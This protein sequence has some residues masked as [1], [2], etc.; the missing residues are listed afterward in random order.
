M[1]AEAD[2]DQTFVAG[3]MTPETLRTTP[4]EIAGVE[5]GLRFRPPDRPPRKAGRPHPRSDPDVQP[6]AGLF[7]RSMCCTAIGR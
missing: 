5:S 1:A 6:S 7:R 3:R 2:L 4:A